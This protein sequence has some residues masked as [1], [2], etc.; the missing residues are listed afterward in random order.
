M[1]SADRVIDEIRA[2]RDAMAKECD[3][4]VEK[5]A[6][7]LKDRETQSGRKVVRRPPRPVVVVRKA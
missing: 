1:K 4:D 2:I 6:Q 7:R 5:L 3:Y